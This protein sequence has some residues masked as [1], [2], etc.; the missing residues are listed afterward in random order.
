MHLQLLYLHLRPK[1]A[2]ILGVMQARAIPYS[3][4]AAK[5]LISCQSA[6]KLFFIAGQY[7][8]RRAATAPLFY[9][10]GY[11]RVFYRSL[12]HNMMPREWG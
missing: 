3:V 5:K 11:L 1:Q 10:C 12:D 2:Q 9:I 4:Y 6:A 8:S 7:T